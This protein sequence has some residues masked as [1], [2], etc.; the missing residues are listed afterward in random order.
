MT[1]IRTD[2]WLLDYCENPVKLC[3]KLKAQFHDDVRPSEIH[4]HLSAHGMYRHPPKL[5]DEWIDQLRDLGIWRLVRKEEQELK[6]LW[7]G[8]DVP[9]FIFPSDPY[10]RKLWQDQNGKS[11]LAFPDKLF[12]FISEENAENEI[13]ALFTHEYNH[14]CRLNSYK[15]NINDYQLLDTVV[16]EGVAENAV[17]ERL[18]NAY[19]ADWTAY[20]TDV[21]LEKL[22]RQ[23][24]YPNKSSP[25][26]SR[27]HQE[28]LYG[29]GFCPK[30]T[31]YCVG[32]YIV[33]KYMDATNATT[34]DLLTIEPET[35][36]EGIDKP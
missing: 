24:V 1:V 17:R 35:M 10:N 12:L 8:P 11:G 29:H 14:I 30:M 2:K 13:R 26:S 9:I 18:G 33:R 34:A 4:Q 20:Y 15:K 25:I 19:T 16:L 27:I 36:I 5:G 21:D 31:G 32:Y 28:I 7:N 6:K 22:W 3:Q 23:F